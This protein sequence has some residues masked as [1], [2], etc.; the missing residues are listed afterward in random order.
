[1]K[2]IIEKSQYQRIMEYNLSL[3]RSRSI[4]N[5][6]CVISYCFFFREDFNFYAWKR[7]KVQRVLN[8]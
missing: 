5:Y 3:W 6:F 7:D 2:N 1:M 4:L 8:L